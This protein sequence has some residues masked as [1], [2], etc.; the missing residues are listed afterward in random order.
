MQSCKMFTWCA[1]VVPVHDFEMDC[2]FLSEILL[3]WEKLG[4]KAALTCIRARRPYLLLSVINLQLFSFSSQL[5]QYYRAFSWGQHV[6]CSITQCPRRAQGRLPWDLPSFIRC[7]YGQD[8]PQNR[9][10]KQ[11]GLFLQP[12]KS[13][14]LGLRKG[15]CWPGVKGD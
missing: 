11:Q 10:S 14:V 2:W 5:F 9:D 12:L 1:A 15:V 4:K 8:E 13:A 7:D 3:E 6:L